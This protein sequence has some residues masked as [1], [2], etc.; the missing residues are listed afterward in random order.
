MRHD[1]RLAH[2]LALDRKVAEQIVVVQVG[3]RKC[4]DRAL[5]DERRPAD[6][7]RGR[8][9]VVEDVRPEPAPELNLALVRHA[10]VAA[11]AVETELERGRQRR[12]ALGRPVD[13]QAEDRGQSESV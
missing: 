10:K 3:R 7:E 4:V 5:R 9:V 12:E 2:W 1:R 6:E 13:E 11:V 8:P